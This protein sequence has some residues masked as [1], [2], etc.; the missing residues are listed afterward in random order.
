MHSSLT[1]SRIVMM[2]NLQEVADEADEEGGAERGWSGAE[3]PLAS[4]RSGTRSPSSSPPPGARHRDEL[5]DPVLRPSDL[6]DSP[7]D[8]S[9]EGRILFARA[10]VEDASLATA[11]WRRALQLL[12]GLGGVLL[13]LSMACSSRRAYCS[14]PSLPP[15]EQES[16]TCNHLGLVEQGCAQVH[17][18][19]QLCT[20]AL[21]SAGILLGSAVGMDAPAAAQPG[22]EFTGQEISRAELRTE[23]LELRRQFDS[24]LQAAKQATLEDCTM[25]AAHQRG[26]DAAS[27]V[28]LTER[29]QAVELELNGLKERLQEK[30]QADDVATQLATK[31]DAASMEK[32][33]AALADKSDTAVVNELLAETSKATASTM[34]ALSATVAAKADMSAVTT[35]L[36]DKADATELAGVSSL[37]SDTVEVHSGR[38]ASL[39]AEVAETKSQLAN[40][41]SRE[42]Y[43]SLSAVVSETKEGLSNAERSIDD[44]RDTL[45]ASQDALRQEHGDALSALEA[46]QTAQKTLPNDLAALIEAQAV[47]QHRVT[48]LQTAEDTLQESVNSL[49]DAVEKAKGPVDEMGLRLSAIEV[50]M[51]EANTETKIRY[52][53]S[54]A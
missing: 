21:H 38:L 11:W 46:S 17:G 45:T 32:L 49:D 22:R 42:E 23:I 7:A 18:V 13:L 52:A 6:D 14:R 47:L 53:L 35:L 3:A 25:A 41:V 15:R 19:R 33:V 24:D 29:V 43:S 12:I 2:S 44:V 34:E 27:R 1:A 16:L 54:H 39:A 28:V 10:F 40:G 48:E 50:K 8:S 20:G 37:S 9:R 5:D 36:A 31:A 51:V 26:E 30:A 4:S